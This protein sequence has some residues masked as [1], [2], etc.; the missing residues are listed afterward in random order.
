MAAADAVLLALTAR[1]MRDGTGETGAAWALF[2]AS[3]PYL[4][5]VHA[6]MLLDVLRLGERTG[7]PLRTLVSRSTRPPQPAGDSA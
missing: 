4:A 3:G 7:A 1:V 5:V 6:A 2:K